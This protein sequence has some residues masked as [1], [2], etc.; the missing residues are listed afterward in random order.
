MKHTILV[1][2][3]ALILAGAAP[4]VNAQEPVGKLNCNQTRFFVSGLVPYCEMREISI[5]FAGSLSAQ[6]LNG[7]ISVAPWDG[8]DVVVRAQ[9][10]TAGANQLPA[11]ALAA[12]VTVDTT[13]GIVVGRGPSTSGP[14]NWSLNFEIYVP[15]SAGL[16]LTT[17]NGDIWVGDV[18]G[19]I[20]FSA[21]NGKV[22][23]VG[24]EGD[25]AGHDVNGNITVRAGDHWQ[26]QT[27]NV[28]TVNG[29]IYLS[30][31]GDCSAHIELSTVRGSI[32]TNFAVPSWGRGQRCRSMSGPAAHWCARRLSRGNV[33][34]VEGACR[35]PPIR[36]ASVA[37]P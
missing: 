15:P 30:V 11:E 10:L 29:N 13:G 20:Q 19:A 2:T 7:N 32:S 14:Q 27:L 17:V 34:L 22:S 9:V 23:V 3:A 31:P 33:R 26:G 12:L 21:V 35:A 1:L 25:V 18:Q 4:R 8:Q 36:N 37:Q 5:P 28:Q 24:A 16:S 6:T